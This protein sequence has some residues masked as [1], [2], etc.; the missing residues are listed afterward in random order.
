V[1]ILINLIWTLPIF[2]LLFLADKHLS[3]FKAAPSDL[4][5]QMAAL[6]DDLKRTKARVN[7]IAL[8]VG[9][10]IMDKE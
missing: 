10:K 4:E 8:Q 2:A 7:N 3:R 5:T 6:R 1:D 9:L